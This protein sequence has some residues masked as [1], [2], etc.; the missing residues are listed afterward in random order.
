MHTV[1]RKRELE[2]KFEETRHFGKDVME[3]GVEIRSMGKDEEIRKFTFDLDKPWKREIW[4]SQKKCGGESAVRIE[5]FSHEG[6]PEHVTVSEIK[7]GKLFK[8]EFN[9]LLDSI[10]GGTAPASLVEEHRK[11]LEGFMKSEFFEHAMGMNED[12][13]VRV[14][15]TNPT[16]PGRSINLPTKLVSEM[17]LKDKMS[18]KLEE[19]RGSEGDYLLITPLKTTAIQRRVQEIGN[20]L[21]VPIPEDML[22]IAGL[23]LGDYVEWGR[24]GSLLSLR[25]TEVSNPNARKVHKIGDSIGVTIPKAYAEELEV[26]KGMYGLWTFD[27]DEEGMLRLWL[28]LSKENPHIMAIC[29]SEVGYVEYKKESRKQFHAT[30]PKGMGEWLEARDEVTLEP[31][32]GKLYIRKKQS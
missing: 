24:D 17:L 5:V 26:K 16:N 27:K 4:E 30:I 18:Y 22:L 25:K 6:K 10:A 15:G 3:L 21:Q 29:T 12:Y 2:R 13:S 28:E 11:K 20:S 9:S 31:I 7:E 1:E 19:G 14:Y 8:S 23:K 32:D